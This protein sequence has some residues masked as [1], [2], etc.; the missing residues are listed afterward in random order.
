[1]NGSFAALAVNFIGFQLLWFVAVYGAARGWGAAALL[2]LLAMQAGVWALNR[3]W[4]RDAPLLAVGALACLLCEPLWMAPQL[5]RYVDWPAGWL[6]PAWIWA[7]WL[8]FAVSF[9]YCLAWLRRRLMLAAVFGALGGVFSV[10]VG[11]RLGAADTPHG[12][13]ALAL[14]YGVVWAAVVPGLA[15]LA[16]RLEEERRDYA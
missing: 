7:L 6:A 1:M 10:T 8:G 15:W 11:I 16:R 5:I 2:V 14:V 12:W 13:W 4:R 3:G 9:N